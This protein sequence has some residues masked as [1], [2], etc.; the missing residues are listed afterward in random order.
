M[1]S[2]K[3]WV[4]CTNFLNIRKETWILVNLSMD[5]LGTSI[6][7]PYPMDTG[8]DTNK[9]IVFFGFGHGCQYPGII[10]RKKKT[11]TTGGT[12]AKNSEKSDLIFRWVFMSTVP[13]NILKMWIFFWAVAR[14]S[15]RGVQGRLFFIKLEK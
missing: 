7:Y 2:K 4:S 3:I 13:R 14:H 6:H 9:N 15:S 5:Y 1:C 12:F 8:L 10:S 11:T